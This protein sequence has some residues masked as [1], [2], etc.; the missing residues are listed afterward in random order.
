M[1]T[2]LIH[3]LLLFLL[4]QSTTSV[5]GQLGFDI[6]IPKAKEYED[7]Q[8]RSEKTK[9]GKLGQPGRFIQNTVTHYNYTF[10]AARKLNEVL[11]KA[12]ADFKD[13]YSKLLPFY[14]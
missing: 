3:I 7:R 8:L 2:P 10:N 14:N 5:F 4:I 11:Q 1:R 13:D 6:K 9:E 12:K